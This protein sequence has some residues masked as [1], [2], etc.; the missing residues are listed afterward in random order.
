MTQVDQLI[1]GLLTDPY[2]GG[3]VV[4]AADGGRFDMLD[5]ASGTV[6]D[7]GMVGLNRDLVSG[8]AAPSGGTKQSD[9]GRESGH[10]GVLDYTESLNPALRW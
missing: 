1:S 3:K 7:S 9:V 8:R 10:E 5:P 4:P 6:I 2:I